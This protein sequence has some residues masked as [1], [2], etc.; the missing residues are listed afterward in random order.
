V[1]SKV[2]TTASQGTDS[3]VDSGHI[4]HRAPA[5]LKLTDQLK[6][7]YFRSNE[8]QVYTSAFYPAAQTI[9]ARYSGSTTVDTR[10]PA[11]ISL[12]KNIKDIQTY[13]YDTLKAND[14]W[15]ARDTVGI[16]LVPDT[17][18]QSLLVYRRNQI[19]SVLRSFLPIQV[20]TVLIIDQAFLESV[21]TY[22]DPKAAEPVLIR[23]QMIDTIMSEVFWGPL[24]NAD[25]GPAET[26]F[27]QAGFRFLR[28]FDG[29][30][31]DGLLPDLSQQPPTLSFRL[32]KRD[33]KEPEGE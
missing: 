12:R 33:V 6:K 30:S 8:S 24:S 32:F 26:G 3:Q 23:E 19:E 13:T 14:N 7:L 31:G 17:V 16:Y 15:Y 28:T 20:R 29:E 5:V 25:R 21:Y 27:Y 11:K 9:D 22:E 18:D 10:N 1:W 2:I 4:T